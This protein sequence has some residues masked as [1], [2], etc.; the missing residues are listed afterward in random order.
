MRERTFAWNF[1]AKIMKLG[2]R[3]GYAA[4]FPVFLL[5]ST[6]EGRLKREIQD[7]IEEL[8]M[9][10]HITK[11]QVAIIQEFLTHVEE[12]L[13][14]ENQRGPPSQQRVE[15]W[16]QFKKIHGRVLRTVQAALEELQMLQTTARNTSQAVSRSHN[17]ALFLC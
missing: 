8:D 12:F 5:D 6:P 4:E 3:G 16:L 1:D 9:M 15:A 2:K 7:I 17:M 14:P 13:G 11:R 10:I